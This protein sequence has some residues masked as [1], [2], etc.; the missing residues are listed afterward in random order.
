MQEPFPMP[1]GDR[2]WSSVHRRTNVGRALF[3]GFMAGFFFG[4]VAWAILMQGPGALGAGVLGGIVFAFVAKLLADKRTQ[5]WKLE[6]EAIA[7]AAR[8]ARE[9]EVQRKIAEMKRRESLSEE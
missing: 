7:R 2:P 4:G 9:E 1:T 8:Q 5:R 3:A 6:D